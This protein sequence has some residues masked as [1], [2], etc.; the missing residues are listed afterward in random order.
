MADFDM[1]LS[2]SIADLIK[3]SQVRT[4]NFR[5]C[6]CS[7]VEVSQELAEVGAMSLALD[8]PRQLANVEHRCSCRSSRCCRSRRR[9]GGGRRCRH[10]GGCRRGRRGRRQGNGGRRG[11]GG[12][13]HRGDRG[14]RG[15][16]WRL[17]RRL[18][19]RRRGRSGRRLG[20]HG[21]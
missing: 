14:R 16:W 2:N 4:F 18:P 3:L 12:R 7:L 19:R 11:R 1:E 13:H 17:R 21:E 15:S 8:G 9:R 10:C 5:C 6:A 20:R